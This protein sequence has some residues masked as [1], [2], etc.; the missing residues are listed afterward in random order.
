[1]PTVVV[2]PRA[3]SV[4]PGGKTV[5]EPRRSPVHRD[6]HDETK[7]HVGE[8]RDR[9]RCAHHHEV[10]NRLE[11]LVDGDHAWA[12]ATTASAFIGSIGIGKR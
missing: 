5:A 12:I 2:R 10:Q 11:V 3:A 4:A 9:E 8:Q 7:R 6:T 1:M